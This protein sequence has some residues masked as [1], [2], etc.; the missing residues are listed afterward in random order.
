MGSKK[1]STTEN[2]Y[3]WKFTP[4]TA[5][6]SALRGFQPQADP[7][8]PYRFGRQR[9]DFLRTFQNPMGSY[10]TPELREQMQR[11]GL[12][13]IGQ[14]EQQAMRENQYDLNRINLAKHEGLA[15]LTSPRLVQTKGTSIE[16][17]GGGLLG[18][19]IGGAAT[20]G[21]AFI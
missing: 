7:S 20:I 18:S 13:S 21:S 9:Q 14:Q 8:T 3:D 4:D 2:A 19:I 15:Q 5:D 1:T 12:E 17:G 11:G 10:T 16:K 6:I